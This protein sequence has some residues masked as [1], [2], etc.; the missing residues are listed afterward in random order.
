MVR[1]QDDL[2]RESPQGTPSTHTSS[3][4]AASI[5]RHLAGGTLDVVG[6]LAGLLVNPGGVDQAAADPAEIQVGDKI[7]SGGARHVGNEGLGVP[8]Q[9]VEEAALSDIGPAGQNHADPLGGFDAFCHPLGK[10]IDLRHGCLKVLPEVFPV[11]ERQVLVGK[12]QAGFQ[13]GQKTEDRLAEPA[14]RLGDA[15]G[16]LD[17]GGVQ[18]PVVGGLDRSEDGFRLGQIGIRPERNARKVNSP[19]SA[20]R[21][22]ARRGLRARVAARG[23]PSV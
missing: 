23:L 5:I 21:A 7:V 9:G 20:S 3:T 19:C 15:A 17:Q 16:E 2:P 8:C 1:L 18:L 4:S 11:Q 22:P 13:V 6:G 12:I 14:E 10:P